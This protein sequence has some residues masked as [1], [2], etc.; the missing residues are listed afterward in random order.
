MA[1][2][3]TSVAV[4][5]LGTFGQSLSRALKQGNADVVAIDRHDHN[6]EA[7]RSIVDFALT[8][9]STDPAV[10][11]SAGVVDCDVAVVA[12][13]ENTESSIITTL[14][15]QDLGIGTI[16]A[17]A[18]TAMHRRVLSKLG[19]AQ[20]INPEEESAVRLA[21]NLSH[22][23]L[24]QLVD[25]GEGYAFVVVSAPPSM[26]GSTMAKLNLRRSFRVNVVGI[27]RATPG[28]TEDGVDFTYSRFL[29]PDG[30]TVVEETD[31]LLVVGRPEDIRRLAAETTGRE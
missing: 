14:N 15:L 27:R 8:G 17:R 12:I 24:E 31:R 21:A 30:A 2:E 9:D 11:K 20:I 29:L 3:R 6:V 7:M 26:A 18:M 16:Y 22:R 13:G 5:G 4:L 19:I 28:A 25:L 23:S 1:Q 10:L